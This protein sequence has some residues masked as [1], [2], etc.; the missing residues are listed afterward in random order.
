MSVDSKAFVK[1]L[2]KYETKVE[3]AFE[4]SMEK[5]VDVLEKEAQALAP[6][7]SGELE[8]NTDTQVRRS[9][10]NIVGTLQFTTEYAAL[11]HNK[12]DSKPGPGT[13]GKSSTKYGN[14]GPNY[15]QDPARGLGKDKTYHKIIKEEVE[16]IK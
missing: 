1:S 8:R 4:K 6:F 11:R 15:I 12:L 3:K 9:G 14:P 2:R 13:R 16:K 10:N 7:R 5:S